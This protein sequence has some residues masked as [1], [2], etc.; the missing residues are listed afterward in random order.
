MSRRSR[1]EGRTSAFAENPRHRVRRSLGEGGT[2]ATLLTSSVVVPRMAQELMRHS[3][4]RL[5]MNVYTHLELAET[6]AAVEALPTFTARM[7]SLVKTGT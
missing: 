5:T 7:E 1:S 2:S 6:R 3:D 4:I